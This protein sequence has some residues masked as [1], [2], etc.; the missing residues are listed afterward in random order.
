MRAHPA[1]PLVE[2]KKETVEGGLDGSSTPLRGSCPRGGSDKRGLRSGVE[3][4][5]GEPSSGSTPDQQDL[6]AD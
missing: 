2:I 3:E 1:R 6:Y 5:G 4:G